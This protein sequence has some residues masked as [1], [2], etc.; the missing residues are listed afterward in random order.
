M[1]RLSPLGGRLDL[2]LFAFGVQLGK[3]LLEGRKSGPESICFAFQRQLFIL[4]RG[5]GVPE[6]PALPSGKTRGV[7]LVSPAP[8]AAPPE[9]RASAGQRP[10]CSTGISA[11]SSAAS[12]HGPHAPRSCSIKTWHFIHLLIIFTFIV[13][14]N[15]NP[16]PRE[17]RGVPF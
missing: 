7:I 9:E 6:S 2:P 4:R 1:Q 3:A 12:R 8:S 17:S 14:R 11:E 5:R 10:A 16:F 15:Q 13:L